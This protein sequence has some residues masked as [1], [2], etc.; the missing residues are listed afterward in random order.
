MLRLITHEM[1]DNAFSFYKG[2]VSIENR[3]GEEE[4]LDISVERFI[5]ICL[6]YLNKIQSF[7]SN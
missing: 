6:L 1:S 7:S 3:K 5:L 2:P 4:G